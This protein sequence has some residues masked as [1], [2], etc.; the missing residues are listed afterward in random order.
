M[1][2]IYPAHDRPRGR[3]TRRGRNHDRK[4]TEAGRAGCPGEVG[5]DYPR[6]RHVEKKLEIRK[7]G[8]GEKREAK[9]CRDLK[10]EINE[11]GEEEKP[12]AG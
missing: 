10:C 2:F 4:E 5:Q 6:T 8:R 1:T 3:A 9:R 7:I 12:K 11:P